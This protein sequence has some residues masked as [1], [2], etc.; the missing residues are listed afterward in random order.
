[1][2]GCQQ[3]NCIC[4]ATV[5]CLFQPYGGPKDEE[6]GW[7]RRLAVA[8][9]RQETGPVGSG[10]FGFVTE[11]GSWAVGAFARENKETASKTLPNATLYITDPIQTCSPA[12]TGRRMTPWTIAR[13]ENTA[14][15]SNNKNGRC[16]LM[17]VEGNYVFI[18][19][20][21]LNQCF[22]KILPVLLHACENLSHDRTG[23]SRI[24]CWGRWTDSEGRC[25]KEMEKI[26]S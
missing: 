12:P 1:V 2:A 23:C 4:P 9:D 15:L 19:R 25:D 7:F 26:P 20:I 5:A 14:I 10:M 22:N 8:S 13:S 16:V 3:T 6:G 21:G 18:L 17:C 11:E 24:G